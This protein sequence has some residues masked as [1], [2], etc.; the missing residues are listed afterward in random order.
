VGAD[1]GRDR[2]AGTACF[3]DGHAATRARRAEGE[4]A[5]GH[6][7]EAFVANYAEEERRERGKH[8]RY[9]GEVLCAETF[10]WQQRG[11]RHRGEGEAWRPVAVQARVEKG[12]VL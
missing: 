9:L 7:H 6:V 10:R 11:R 2:L 1:G 12:I 5:R 3:A 8:S 4:D